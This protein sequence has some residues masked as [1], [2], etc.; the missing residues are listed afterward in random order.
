MT[1]EVS[2]DALL[3]ITLTLDMTRL[4]EHMYP[5]TSWNGDP[6]VEPP[7]PFDN[8]ATA[9]TQMMVHQLMPK[10]EREV[11]KMVTEQL[12]EQAEIMVADVIAK[13]LEEGIQK[14]NT[15]G[16]ATGQRTTLREMVVSS[17]K[18]TL[19]RKVD[20]RGQPSNGYG[21]RESITWIQYL[22]NSS[23]QEAMR[24]HIS[25]VVE[26]ATLEVKEK[27]QAASAK[28]ISDQIVKSLR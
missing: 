21:S 13:T 27:I 8:A 19:E 5:N 20:Y 11:T 9:V 14:T 16:E 2:A 7:E 4:A 26:S 25:G 6:D 10:I 18:D 15:F 24:E 23:V 1:N 12:K 22:I 17:A 3:P 28:A